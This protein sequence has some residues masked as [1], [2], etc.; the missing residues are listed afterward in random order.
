MPRILFVL[1]LALSAQAESLGRQAKLYS[2]LRDAPPINGD[3]I[4]PAEHYFGNA[5]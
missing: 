4:Y 5:L 2:P 1:I 3:R